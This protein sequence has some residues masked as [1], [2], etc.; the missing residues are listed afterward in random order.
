MARNVSTPR[1]WTHSTISS[2][3]ADAGTVLTLL[4]SLLLPPLI[5]HSILVTICTT[6]LNIQELSILPTKW[7][8]FSMTL[9][10]KSD[11]FPG[12]HW[13]ASRHGQRPRQRDIDTRKSTTNKHALQHEDI[14][15]YNNGQHY[16]IVKVLFTSFH[17][18][19]NKLQIHL[20][21]T[22][23]DSFNLFY[24]ITFIVMGLVNLTKTTVL[25]PTSNVV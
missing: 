7:V 1:R 20:G 23:S 15:R 17:P 2:P 21:A 5:L 8:H 16:R 13:E 14:G 24:L 19:L 6:H 22:K 9:R 3:L 11:Y 4:F 12:H 25:D 10:T 18:I